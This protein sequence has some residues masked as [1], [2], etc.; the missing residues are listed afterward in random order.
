MPSEPF[1]GA[2]IAL[3]CQGQV[4]AYQRDAKPGIPWPGLWDLPGGGREGEET[5]L[6]CALRETTEEFSL[7]IAPSSVVLARAYP[8]HAHTSLPTWFFVARVA[9]GTFDQVRFGDEGQRWAVLGTDA[10]I[11]HP[12]AVPHLQVRL[13]ECLGALA[14]QE[15]ER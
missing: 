1:S 8:G 4:L 11:D 6:A 7:R 2:K 3:L 10:F 5:P 12:A 9:P 15:D 14:S 13:R